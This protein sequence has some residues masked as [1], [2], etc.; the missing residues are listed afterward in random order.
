VFSNT[1][2]GE[3]KR[4]RK[5]KQTLL[6]RA[7]VE[8]SRANAEAAQLRLKLNE[9]EEKQFAREREEINATKEL[10]RLERAASLYIPKAVNRTADPILD[11]RSRADFS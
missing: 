1:E 11:P 6:L 8:A 3:I 9:L 2:R 5:R 4:E 7:E 10:E